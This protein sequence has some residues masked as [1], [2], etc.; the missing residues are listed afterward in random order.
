MN[1]ATAYVSSKAY[2]EAGVSP[3]DIQVAGFT[4]PLHH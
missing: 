1:L 3:K 2:Q 4:M